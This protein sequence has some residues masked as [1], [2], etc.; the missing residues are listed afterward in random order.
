MRFLKK[1]A[2]VL[3]VATLVITALLLVGLMMVPQ[4]GQKIGIR[5]AC[6]DTCGEY[7]CQQIFGYGW[8]D[9]GCVYGGIATGCHGYCKKPKWWGMSFEIKDCY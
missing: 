9:M 7:R 1:N 3:I 6:A 5:P 8:K 4:Q 2:R